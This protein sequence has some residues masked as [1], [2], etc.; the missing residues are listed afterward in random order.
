MKN[1]TQKT[2]VIKGTSYLIE[3]CRGYFSTRFYY[4][5]WRCDGQS[6]L[7]SLGTFDSIATFRRHAKRGTL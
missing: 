5:V 2:V 1:G 4:R 7:D 6:R 3:K